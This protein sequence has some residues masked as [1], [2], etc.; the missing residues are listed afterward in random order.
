MWSQYKEIE[1][2]IYYSDPTLDFPK[3]DYTK[4]ENLYLKIQKNLLTAFL[5]LFEIMK[6]LVRLPHI[7]ACDISS[8]VE[9]YVDIKTKVLKDVRVQFPEMYKQICKL[10]MNQ[11]NSWNENIL[12]FQFKYH[13]QDLERLDLYFKG[14]DRANKFAKQEFNLDSFFKVNRYKSIY[15]KDL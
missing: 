12:N 13:A 15:G 7:C 1:I 4:P 9:N 5:E 6:I 2:G 11:Y 14:F 3:V 10:K 8:N